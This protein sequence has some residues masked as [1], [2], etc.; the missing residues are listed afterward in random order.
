LRRELE[1]VEIRYTLM[2][3]D[4]ERAERGLYR[5]RALPYYWYKRTVRARDDRVGPNDAIDVLAVRG[6]GVVGLRR[7]IKKIEQVF[8][9]SKCAE[10]DK[11][12]FTASTVEGRAL[13]W[14][15]ENVHTLG[16]ANANSIHWNEFKAMMTTEYCP[17]IE[18]QRM[19]QELWTLTLK[20]D[21]IE[22][23]NNRFHKL[24]LMCLDL[25]PTEKKKIERYIK[26]FLER[27]KGNITSSKPTTL[28]D[29]VNMAHELI[30]QAGQGRAVRIRENNK[31]KW[32]EHQRNTDNN[33]PNHH[34]NRNQMHNNHHQQQNR[35]Q[36]AT[37]AYV[38]A[39]AENRGYV[40]HLP[41][42]NH[43]NS[44]HNGQCPPKSQR[45][46]RTGHQEKDCKVRLPDIAP[47]T[48]NTSYK[49]DLADGKVTDGKFKS[50]DRGFVAS[51]V[52]GG[53]GVDCGDEGLKDCNDCGIK[54]EY[55]DSASLLVNSSLVISGTPGL[56]PIP[57]F[58]TEDKDFTR[59]SLMTIPVVGASE[60]F[61]AG[62]LTL[63][64]FLVG[65]SSEVRTLESLGEAGFLNFLAF[66]RGLPPVREIEFRIDLISGALP[67]VNLPYRLAPLE[68]S[69]QLKELQK[70]GFIQPNHSPWGAPVLFVK[71]K[72]GALRM[73]IDYREQ[74]TLT[75]KNRYPLPKI[76]DLFDQL[77]GV[78]CFS[79]IDLCSRYHQLR[80]REEYIPKTTFRTCYGQFEF[81][82]MP[83]GLTNA[84]ASLWT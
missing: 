80:V 42:C 8:E 40:V 28:H 60:D 17:V 75:I 43:C 13:I 82:V 24:D 6:E 55:T 26:G 59:V 5:L 81:M 68:M 53:V 52:G 22:A 46:Q 77:Q 61:L 49:V 57:S 47:A 3:M 72:N 73:C 50:V 56:T 32:E 70:K 19:E 14:W 30:E 10:G 51:V 9:I 18:I 44:D 4:R 65:S 36:E 83:F 12:M 69:N 31:R 74:N 67:V 16:L 35:R 1:D 78:H 48:L 7:W 27:I 15:N 58:V 41:K 45:C 37:S 20:G 54:V 39:P 11:V 25:V 62:L 66:L 76:D 21:D 84:P 2:R 64:D 63:F 23:Y 33:N 79:K 34:K 71:K 29:A 38:A